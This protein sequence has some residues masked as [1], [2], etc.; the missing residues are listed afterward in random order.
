MIPY[1]LYMRNFMCYREQ[2]LDFRGIDLACLTGDNGNGKSA[3]LDAITWA[4][5]GYSRVGARRDDEL[6]HLG[7]TEMEVE[8]AFTL[9]QRKGAAEEDAIRYR[10]IRKRSRKGRGQSSLELQGWDPERN[11]FRPMTEPT[12]AQTQERINELLRMDYETFINSAFL[13]Q[14]RADEFTI[15]RPSERKRVLGDILGLQVYD[16]YEQRAKDAAQERKAHADQTRATIEQIDRE[17][18][19][20]DEYRAEVAA[21]EVAL[22]ELQAQR[23]QTEQQYDQIRT[24]LQE[25][26]SAQQQLA[27]LKRRI[28]DAEAE[29]AR[30]LRELATHSER[31]QA[32]ESAL[33]DADAIERGFDDY[34][35]A[36]A[37]NEAM[38]KK[39]AESASLKEQRS[40]LEQGIAAARHAIDKE[41]YAAAERVRQ[42]EAAASALEHEA[43]WDEIRQ[44]LLRLDARATERDA[45][46]AEIQ[47]LSAATAALQADNARAQEDAAQ[48][49]DK[50]D[51][52][53]AGGEEGSA[54]G[55]RCPLCG[56]PLAG[57]S[58]ADLLSTFRTQLDQER[59]AYRQ[60]NEQINEH[61]R[62]IASCQ[63]TIAE[64]DRA[65][66]QR[67]GWQRKEAAL[68]H[69]LEEARQAEQAM[70]QA[71]AE[72][73]GVEARLRDG[74]FALD[75]RASLDEVEH[76]LGELGYDAQAHRRL[77]GRLDDLR[78]YEGQ[79]Q[80]LRE[81]RSSLDT[82]RLAIS[83]LAQS[84][85]QAAARLDAGRAQALALEE[86][87]RQ[88]PDLQ[89]QALAARQVLESAHDR[90]QQAGLRLGAA[91]NK[92]EHCADLKRQRVQRVEQERALREEQGIYQELQRAFGKNGVQAMLIESA[93]PE[94]EEESN[95]LLTRMSRGRM[96]VRFETQRDT[97][98]G[99]TIETLD[100]HIT[101]ELG[102]RSYETYSGGE[103]YRINFAI[104]I[105]L[106]KLLA[107]RAGAQLQTLVIDEGFGTQD[108][109]GRDGLIDA[110]NA[111]QDDFA[112][113]LAI[114]HIED[115]KNAFNVRIEVDK[116]P[117]G[118]Q[119]T[120]V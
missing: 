103:R 82:V 70:P 21:A 4:L 57:K 12:I 36:I 40:E 41:R 13:L 90:E 60:R 3:I 108:N 99:D 37:A 25:A 38:N 104:R 119:I 118:S 80:T 1:R 50:I 87:V 34:Q 109:E 45:L 67:A 16:R 107:H 116:T 8:F 20:E 84:Q 111:I 22:A 18:G 91:R 47:A 29:Q 27:D 86:T 35:R 102:T 96:H 6:I 93:I 100:I 98:R 48:L 72:L 31:L 65:L 11:Q 69:V 77:Q 112:C 71:R 19:R 74:Q 44:T 54:E 62:R 114:T 92:V 49:K 9:V 52:L 63:G 68:A 43:E 14:G 79:M 28:A 85:E 59:A 56:Q 53:A 51:L 89:R 66:Q 120:V 32:L 24:A 117:Q 55:A 75:L 94:I 101:D 64:I 83:Q 73:E 17:I 39:L 78:P 115:L 88:I 26:E 33:A 105:A 23:V 42:L 15:K 95:R 113:I 10:A 106:S 58:C 7:Q 5:W 81:A 76:H 61:G 30:L 46:Q 110:I 2:T 97:K